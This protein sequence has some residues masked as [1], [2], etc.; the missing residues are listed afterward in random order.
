M[1][2]SITLFIAFTL[3]LTCIAQQKIKVLVIGTYHMGNPGLDK[4]NMKADD[5]STPERQKEI[6]EFTDALARFKPSIVCVESSYS[7]N[8]KL[9]SQYQSYLTGTYQLT[10]NEVDQVG[11]RLAKVSGLTEVYG[12]DAKA[13]F[14]MDSVIALAQKSNNTKFL[15]GLN[16]IGKMVEDM[17]QKLYQLSISQY[18]LYLNDPKLV[19]TGHQLY[20]SMA[21]VCQGENYAG[22]DVVADWYERNLRIYGN[23]SRIPQKAGDRI[24][25]LYGQGHLKILQDLIRDSNDYELVE[26]KDVLISSVKK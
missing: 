24:V 22:A 21:R 13:P 17:N 18:Y 11:L 23:L 1:I 25:I 19:T 6:K 5:V 12:I 7:K 10:N 8:N 3:S 2:R 4:F 20:L 15:E 16:G 26:L 14:E 9:N